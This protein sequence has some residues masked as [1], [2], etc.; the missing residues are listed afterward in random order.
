MIKKIFL[1]ITNVISVLLIA[2]SIFILLSVIFSSSGKAPN[3]AGYSLFRV[4][5]GSMEPAIPEGSLL[6]IKKTDPSALQVGDVISFYSKDPSLNG[7]VNTHRIMEIE[8]ENGTYLFTTKGDANN[9][10]DIYGTLG[11]DVI[12]KVVF[13]SLFLGKIVRLLSNPLIFL[14]VVILPLTIIIITNL[15]RSMKLARKIA[16]EE[17]EAAIREAIEKIRNK[18]KEEE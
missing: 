10:K 4:L 12:G 3:I 2:C 14:P 17:E 15:I 8:E 13:S 9:V 7:E 1:K 16:K 11:S 6:L 18:K 5:T